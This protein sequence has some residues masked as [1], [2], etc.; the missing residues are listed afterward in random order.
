VWVAIYRVGESGFSISVRDEGIGF[1][2]D[3]ELRKGKGLGMRLV[4][5]FA[6]QLGGTVQI[7]ARNPGAEFMVIIPQSSGPKQFNSESSTT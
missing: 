4:N 1:S 2:A 6:Q 3:F 7:N 5:A